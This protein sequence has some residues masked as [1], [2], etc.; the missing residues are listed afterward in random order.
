MCAL[1]SWGTIDVRVSATDY[2]YVA[3]KMVPPNSNN[4]EGYEL[5]NLTS[6][7]IKLCVS[8]MHIVHTSVTKWTHCPLVPSLMHFVCALKYVFLCTLAHLSTCV[9][10]QTRT[11]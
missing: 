4:I 10:A 8:V 2:D 5:R 3:L 9:R 7:H 11:A 6:F 1:Q